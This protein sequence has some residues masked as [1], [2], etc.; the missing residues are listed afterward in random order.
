MK[1]K[2]RGCMFWVI[3]EEGLNGVE[4]A[5]GLNSVLNIRQACDS[6]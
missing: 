3:G 4:Y 6:S 2:P 1:V 5:K